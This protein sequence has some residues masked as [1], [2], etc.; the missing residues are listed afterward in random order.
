MDRI[1][2][3][4]LGSF[5]VSATVNNTAVNVGV[6]LFVLIK[7]FLQ[8]AQFFCVQFK[9]CFQDERIHVTAPR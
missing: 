7:Q 1:L 3:I 5:R 8:S 2:L 6:F 9:G 4:N